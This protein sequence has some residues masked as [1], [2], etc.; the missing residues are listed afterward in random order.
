MKRT[1]VDGTTNKLKAD[2]SINY[3]VSPQGGITKMPHEPFKHYEKN[4]ET[5]CAISSELE[6][7]NEQF[8]NADR[9]TQRRMLLDSYIFAVISVQTPLDRHEEAFHAYI[10]GERELENDAMKKVNYWKNKISYIRETE[11]RFEDIDEAIDLLESGTLDLAHR[12]I[13]DTF[14][15]VRTKKAGFTMAMLGFTGKMCV[16]TNVKQM[17]GLTDQQEYTGVVIE[18]YEEQCD[19]IRSKF[20]QLDDKLSPFMV[21]WVLFDSIRES[22]TLHREFLTHQLELAE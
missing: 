1:A 8:L 16:D 2:W 12:Y 5:Y 10:S 7:I 21:Q 15:G 18:K 3:P 4:R 20:S 19:S 22:V 9:N 17:A 6:E 13:A 14:K 11:T